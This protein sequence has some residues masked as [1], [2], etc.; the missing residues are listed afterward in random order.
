MALIGGGGGGI[1][2]EMEAENATTL[3]E[4]LRARDEHKTFGSF[5]SIV[6]PLSFIGH[7]VRWWGCQSHCH[8]VLICYSL[9]WSPHPK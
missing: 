8:T 2:G 9:H 7:W 5:E 3:S 6:D 4:E 1:T